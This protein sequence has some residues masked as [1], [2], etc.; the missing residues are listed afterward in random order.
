MID[1]S[2]VLMSVVLCIVL[3]SRLVRWAISRAVPWGRHTA[4]TAALVPLAIGCA[5]ALLWASSPAAQVTEA[6]TPPASQVFIGTN[7]DGL[8]VR[9]ATG[10]VQRN[11]GHDL[12]TINVVLSPAGLL[13]TVYIFGTGPAGRKAY[14]SADGAVTWTQIADSPGSTNS[15]AARPGEDTLYALSGGTVYKSI[16]GGTWSVTALGSYTNPPRCNFGGYTTAVKGFALPSAPGSRRIWFTREP[17][18]P[19]SDGSNC[20]NSLHYT[21]DEGATWFGGFGGYGGG[22]GH[23]LFASADPDRVYLGYGGGAVTGFDLTSPTSATSFTVTGPTLPANATYVVN[24]R[25][26]VVEYFPPNPSAPTATYGMH[27]SDDGGA[28]YTATTASVAGPNFT[29]DPGA[30]A[31]WWVTTGGVAAVSTDD[32]RTWTTETTGFASALS[33]TIAGAYVAVE[34]APPGTELFKAPFVGESPDPVNTITGSFGYQRTDLTIA[35]RGPTPSFTRTYNSDDTRVGPLGPGWTHTYNVRLRDPGD[36]TEALILVSVNGRSDRYAK[37]PDGSYTG[38]AGIQ[39]TLVRQSDGTFLATH[40]DQSAWSFNRNGRLVTITDRH[41]NRSTLTYDAAGRLLTIG[42]PAGRG[43]LTLTYDGDRLIR[44]S[45]WLSPARMIEYGYDT[46]TPRRLKTVTDREGGVTTYGYDGASQRLTTITDA[47]GHIAVTNAYDTQGRV[48]TQKDARGLATGQ[49]TTFSYMA[50]GDGTRTTVT[51]LPATSYEPSWSPTITDTY[52]SQGRLTQRVTRP[53]SNPAENVTVTHT[54]D[55]AGNLA[56][57]TDSLGR[58]TSFCY[59]IDE[60]GITIPGS[61]G[62]LTRRIDPA[63]ASSGNVLVTLSRYDQHGNLTRAILPK[64]VASG[65]SVSCA[66]DLSASLDLTYA[67]TMTYD[68]TGTKLLATSRSTTDPDNPG[69]VIAATTAYEYDASQPGL[70]SRVIPPRGTAGSSPDYSYATSFSYFGS[71]SKHGLLQSV[72]DPLGNVTTFDYDAVGRR[73]SLV[74]PNGN[75]P[76]ASAAEH[77]W[78][79]IYDKEGRLRFARTP[80]PTAGGAQLVTESRYDG[81]GNLTA[82]IDA[83]GQVTRYLYDERDG[84]QEVWESPQPWTDPSSTPNPKIVTAYQYD[85]LGNLTRVIRAKDD[86]ANERVVD[87]AYDGL[88]RVRTE[89]QYPDWPSTSGALTMQTTYDANGNRASVVDQLG[90]TT[91]YSYDRLNRLT[92]IDYADAATPDVSYTYDANGSRLTMVDGTGTTTYQYDEQGRLLG[93]TS[94]GARTVAY[95]YDRDGNRTTLRY[96]NGDAVSYA[97]DKGGRLTTLTDWANRVTSYAYVPDGALKTQTNVNGTTAAYTYDNARRLLDVW[98]QKPGTP[99]ETIARHQFTLDG[100]GNRTQVAETLAPL[101]QPPI[102]PTT[103]TGLPNRGTLTPTGGAPTAL[104]SRPVGTATATPTGLPNRPG[105]PTGPT[106]Q[107][108]TYGYDRLNRLTSAAGG[109][110]GTTSYSYD[111]VGNR[112][113]RVRGSTTTSYSYDRADRIASAGGVSYSVDANGNLIARGTDTFAYDQANRLTQTT[114]GGSA[115][116]YTYDGNGNRTSVTAGSGTTQYLYDVNRSLPVVLEDGTRRYVWGLGL[117]YAVE[118][119]SALVYHV[120]G[121]GSVRAITDSTKAVVQTYQSDE[122]GVPI[123]TQGGSTQPFGFTGEQRDA[124]GLVY[125]RARLYDP[126][127]GRFITRDRLSGSSR[128]PRTLNRYVYANQNPCTLTDPSGYKAQVLA[129]CGKPPDIPDV[130]DGVDVGQLLQE[131]ME[132]ARNLTDLSFVGNVA[133]GGRWDYKSVWYPQDTSKYARFG[134][135]HFGAV[136]AAHG[137]TLGT[138]AR[139]AGLVQMGQNLVRQLTGLPQAPSEGWPL[140]LQRRVLRPATMGVAA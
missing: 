59:D 23:S 30:P 66:T 31:V 27:V 26:H 47:N 132:H 33:M 117:A 85:H 89:P 140:V 1:N 99:T 105:Q 62:Q 82:S 73:I 48:Q 17:V 98:N 74:D 122:F 116:S 77:R 40:Q 18:G 80:A 35:G 50:N 42:D 134:N 138:A 49:A 5:A 71:G 7:G 13:R 55:L 69:Q 118:G 44:V 21:D 58:T 28:T 22:P 76:G 63:P 133:P 93:V 106:T 84:L 8:L 45:D 87:Y 100:V 139:G 38:P 46:N 32:G 41:G 60:A 120:D 129:E 101:W 81:V 20:D 124:T 95:R 70:V 4:W 72:T 90:R 25:D 51:V 125:L 91:S 34:P 136:A 111:P 57:M 128:S 24:T 43:V 61:R 123:A 79:Y 37:N 64:G 65:T 52:D 54:Y 15:I 68:A 113:T 126:T 3:L 11:S 67:T 88:N 36:G 6:Q 104:P 96:P 83:N 94:P 10:W 110:A 75:T 78:E 112:L 102:T 135:F 103:P 86:P 137:F 19:N 14:K 115:A 39:T 130:P 16:G 92:G 107:T 56:S 2:A 53:T 97:F 29:Y 127:L 131:N 108:L 119:M 121:L 114:V 109:P 9:T 12:T